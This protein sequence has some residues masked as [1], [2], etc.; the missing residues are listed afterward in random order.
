MTILAIATITT[1]NDFDNPA[2]ATATSSGNSSSN[3]NA[4]NNSNKTAGGVTAN[5]VDTFRTNGQI[6]SLASDIM[7]GRPSANSS[8]FEEDAAGRL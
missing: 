1:N 5:N 4:N 7:T 2:L 8:Q 6:S 3:N